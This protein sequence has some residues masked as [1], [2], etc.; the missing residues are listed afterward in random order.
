[1]TLSLISLQLQWT[2][3]AHEL[4]SGCRSVLNHAHTAHS[5]RGNIKATY[6][7]SQHCQAPDIYNIMSYSR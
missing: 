5:R 4:N 6:V 2:V 3:T 7:P 1:M